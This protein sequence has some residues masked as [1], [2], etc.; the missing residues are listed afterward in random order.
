MKAQACV[1]VATGV[2]ESLELLQGTTVLELDAGALEELDAITELLEA[3]TLIDAVSV[4]ASKS[5]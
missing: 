5:L 4:C 2:V 1:V 3:G